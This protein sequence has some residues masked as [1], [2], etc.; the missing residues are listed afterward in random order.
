MCYARFAGSVRPGHLSP[1][2]TWAALLCQQLWRMGMVG[3]RV[4]SLA[5]FF[6]SHGAWGLAVAG[7]PSCVPAIQGELRKEPP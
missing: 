5:L 6:R 1:P 3:A 4:L 2:W 7:K